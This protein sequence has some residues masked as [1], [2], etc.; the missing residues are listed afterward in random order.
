MCFAALASGS[1]AEPTVFMSPVR[2]NPEQARRLP[3]ALTNAILVCHG[4]YACRHDHGVHDELDESIRHGGNQ[5]NCQNV[6]KHDLGYDVQD[7]FG[8]ASQLRRELESDT[9]RIKR[10]YVCYQGYEQRDQEWQFGTK[11]YS[12]AWE[13]CW[14][15]HNDGGFD[16][17]VEISR[18]NGV[19][20]PQ[21]RDQDLHAMDTAHVWGF[22]GLSSIHLTNSDGAACNR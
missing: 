18:C 9:C 14:R 3:L 4:E 19:A 13:C 20:E 6:R 7:D 15:R 22:L 5:R 2:L 21:V 12:W 1:P 17:I 11:E 8:H 10:D 16:G